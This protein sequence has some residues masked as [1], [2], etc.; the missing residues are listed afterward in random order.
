MPQSSGQTMT[1]FWYKFMLGFGYLGARRMEIG[2]TQGG[3]RR[4]QNLPKSQ[5]LNEYCGFKIR[6]A[7]LVSRQ[8]WSEGTEKKQMYSVK[9]RETF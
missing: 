1:F 4:M 6:E 2:N 3:T 9:E 8:V 7:S 5:C